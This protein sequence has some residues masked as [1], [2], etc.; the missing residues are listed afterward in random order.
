LHH[1]NILPCTSFSPGNFW[2]KI[3][4]LLFPQP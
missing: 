1:D 4:S 3:M 2:P